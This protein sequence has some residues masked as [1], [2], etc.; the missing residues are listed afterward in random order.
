MTKRIRK[1]TACSIALGT[2]SGYSDEEVEFMKAMDDYKRKYGLRFLSCSEILIVANCLG[3]RK[4][5]AKT[6]WPKRG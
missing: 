5:A 2:E 1:R 6:P 3:Y 4:V